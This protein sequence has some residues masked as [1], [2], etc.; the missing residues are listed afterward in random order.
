MLLNKI[1]KKLST[2]ESANPSS[3]KFDSMDDRPFDT[4]SLKMTDE[5]VTKYYYKKYE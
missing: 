5:V 1:L 2:K 4:T 3:N